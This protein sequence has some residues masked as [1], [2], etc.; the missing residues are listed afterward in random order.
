MPSK[1]MYKY[2][3]NLSIK[4]RI[5]LSF[6]LILGISLLF[7]IFNLINLRQYHAQ[8]S[9]YQQVSADTNLM[10]E[11]D[12]GLAELQH[13]ILSFSYDYG[14]VSINKVKDKHK[15][16][17]TEINQLIK[18]HTFQEKADRTLIRQMQTLVNSFDGQFERLGAQR[19]LRD[20]Y[21]N[22]KLVADFEQI[23]QAMLLLSSHVGAAQ[24]KILIKEL[25]EAQIS[26]SEAELI[27]ARYFSSHQFV[28]EK[29]VQ[30]Y[31]RIAEGDL[32]EAIA[33][34]QEESI[35][36]EIRQLNRLLEQAVQTFDQAAQADRD[37]FFLIKI[38]LAGASTEV[39]AMSEKL[40]A[41]A[42]TEQRTLFASAEKEISLNEE[43]AIYTSILNVLV[44]LGLAFVVGRFISKPLKS[45]TE[46]FN[47]LANGEPVM[48]IPGMSRGDEIGDLARAAD[49]VNDA[50]LSTVQ[51]L[52]EAEWIASTLAKREQELEKSNEE[53]HNFT[54]IVSHDLKSPV[55]GIAD[56]VEWIQDDLGADT[57][58]VVSKNLDRVSIR[59]KRMSSL[60]E[61]L[62]LYSK[63][64]ER[65]DDLSLIDPEEMMKEILELLVIPPGIKVAVSGAVAS[66]ESARTPLETTM[67][68]LISN[69][70]KHHDKANGK[71]NINMVEKNDHYQF[72]IHDDGPGIP[73][74]DQEK[75][76]QL[77]QAGS[78]TD[79]STGMGLAFCKRMAEAQG[80]QI[81]IHSKEGEGCTFRV[82]WPKTVRKI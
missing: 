58:E 70:I 19:K 53:L 52:H 46:T 69:A 78:K 33:L 5:L 65:S 43:V 23:Y 32:N 39:S 51:L 72:D 74:S 57:P 48:I 36:R 81:E 44:A 34:A 27:S 11:I 4:Q 26:I 55:Q 1:W 73:E 10:L 47:Q 35:K 31:L 59:V 13:E 61:D 9:Q 29:E 24:D 66:F 2:F 20:G 68:N 21:I 17:T 7:T 64:G 60:I 54:H 80:G 6:S 38:V 67:R 49:V 40:K 3:S 50:N 30:E 63:A 18:Q 77:F 82:F 75:V 42:L 22:H 28:D 79:N 8:F 76:F 37:Y 56:L 25:W 14:V 45:I 12:H 71:I 62:L 15:T 41:K 16:L